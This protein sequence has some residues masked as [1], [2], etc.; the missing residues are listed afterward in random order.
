MLRYAITNL[1]ALVPDPGLT[2]EATRRLHWLR[3][4]ERWAA[5]GVDFVQLREKSL[6][7]GE[8]FALAAAAML[9]LREIAPH[10]NMPENR[11]PRLLLNSR[12]DIAAA[13]HADGVHLTGRPGELTPGQVRLTFQ[14]ATAPHCTV[15][16][17][18]R[19]LEHIKRARDNE[20]DFILLGPVF[21]KVVGDR[22]IVEGTGLD[23]LHA[24]CE[25][26]RPVQ[27]L[28]LGGITRQNTAECLAAGAAGVAAIRL[29]SGPRS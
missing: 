24:A 4:L 19:T 10:G 14:A 12:A 6:D 29:F 7:A 1:N 22:R 23:L 2:P 26:A 8:Q 27:V 18:C 17:S 25:L 16:V 21:E 15:S 13:A 20:A 9:F 28:A 3:N 5:E 11:R